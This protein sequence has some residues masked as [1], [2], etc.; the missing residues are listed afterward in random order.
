[1]L[2][3]KLKEERQ[4]NFYGEVEAKLVKIID[5]DVPRAPVQE[6]LSRLP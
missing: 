5:Y 4:E 3:D 2:L 1:M 6:R